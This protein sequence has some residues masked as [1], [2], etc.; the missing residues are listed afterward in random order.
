MTHKLGAVLGGMLAGVLVVALGVVLPAAPSF[1]LTDRWAAWSP[2]EGSANAF[3]LTMT[4]RS[5]GFPV[6]SVASDSRAPVQVASGLST[7]L[8]PAT[9]PGAKYGSSAGNP[10]LVLRPAV[11]NPTSPSTT[12]YTFATPTPDAGWAFVLGDIDADQV[13]LSATDATGAAVPAAEVD[14][15]FAGR[16]NYAG[17]TDLW[18]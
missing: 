6:A 16:F 5:S 1:A 7:F 13:A 11:D 3:R 18:E 15:W 2:V 4:Q 8:G 12:T 9:P 17:A 14:S 10:Y